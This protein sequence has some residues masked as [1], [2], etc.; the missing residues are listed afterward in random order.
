[1]KGITKKPIISISSGT[2]I[3]MIRV[4]AKILLTQDIRFQSGNDSDC[5]PSLPHVCFR[6]CQGPWRFGRRT[7]PGLDR[8]NGSLSELAADSL[9]ALLF[10]PRKN[11]GQKSR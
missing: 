8:S 7:P 4:R 1:M 10:H 6:R 9:A 3:A 11:R 2:P 5:L